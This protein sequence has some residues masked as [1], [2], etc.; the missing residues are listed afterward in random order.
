MGWNIIPMALFLLEAYHVLGHLAVL[1]RVRLLPRR[2]LV[3]LRAY[4]LVDGLSSLITAFCFTG[5]LQWLVGLHVLQHLY[6]FFFWEKTDLAKRYGVSVVVTVLPTTQMTE[7]VDWSSLDFFHSHKSGGPKC[8]LDNIVGTLF[9]VV[10]HLCNLCVLASYLTTVQVLFVL[11]LAQCSI[12]CVLYNPR[13][14]WS[15]P[16]AMPPWVQKRLSSLR[17]SY[18]GSSDN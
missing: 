7:I 1:L 6:Y 10:V 13:F 12:C 5:R 15:S 17:S 14:A 4:F 16:S 8:E 18:T 2:D 9:D 11:V 3:R